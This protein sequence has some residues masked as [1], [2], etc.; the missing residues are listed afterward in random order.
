MNPAPDS[1]AVSSSTLWRPGT[2]EI[3]H[4][5]GAGGIPPAPR[6]LRLEFP[7]QPLMRLV[8]AAMSALMARK[9][10]VSCVGCGWA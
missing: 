7:A 6:G 5:A 1:S 8:P 3:N 2:G 10:V 4:F 9:I